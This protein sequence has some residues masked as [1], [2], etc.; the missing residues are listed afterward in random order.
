MSG[1][2]DKALKSNYAENKYRFAGQLYDDDLDWDTYQFRF[3]TQDPQLGRFSQVDPLASKY[4]YNTPYAYAENRPIDGIDLEGKEFWRMVG[5]FASGNVSEAGNAVAGMYLGV[6]DDAQQAMQAST[7]LATGTSDQTNG[8]APSEVQSII[9]TANKANDIAASAKPAV[10]VM[11]A[12]AQVVSLTP[13]GEA[14]L[15][16]VVE[17]AAARSFSTAAFD[18]RINIADNFSLNAAPAESSISPKVQRFKMY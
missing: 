7:R 10:D 3:R 1:I 9:N 6:Q 8:R 16:A 2:S 15:P 14:G 18:S 5:A 4:V 13:I 17:N 12:T 11:D